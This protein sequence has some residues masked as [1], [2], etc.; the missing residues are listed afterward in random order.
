[1][2][3]L[4]PIYKAAAAAVVAAASGAPSYMAHTVHPDLPSQHT[5][6]HMTGCT[7]TLSET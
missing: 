4:V 3:A 1:M 7:L 5:H 6:T 2:A